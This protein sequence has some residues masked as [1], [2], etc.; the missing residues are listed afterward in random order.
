M[1]LVKWALTLWLLADDSA[2]GDK[3][4]GFFSVSKA[5]IKQYEV[6]KM[7]KYKYKTNTNTDPASED[8]KKDD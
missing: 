8:V 2:Y 4:Q 3:D 6:I 1:V 7:I 5:K